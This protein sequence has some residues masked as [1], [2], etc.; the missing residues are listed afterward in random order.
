[1]TFCCAHRLV[2]SVVA[3]R[4]TSSSKSI[5]SSENSVELGEKGV[6]GSGGLEEI[7]EGKQWS[8]C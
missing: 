8:D 4:K 2:P 3:I 5:G 7:R 6:S 1:M